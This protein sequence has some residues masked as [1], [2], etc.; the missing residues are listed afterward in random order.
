MIIAC[1]SCGTAIQ[2][3][4]DLESI[5]AL[6]GAKTEF[7]SAGYPCFRCGEKAQAMLTQQVDPEALRSLDVYTLSPEEALAA[8]CGLGIPEERGCYE[9]VVRSLFEAVGVKIGGRQL[10][11][12]S[13]FFLDWL[14]LPSG[15]RIYL[16]AGPSGALVYRITKPHSYVKKVL[17][18]STTP[19]LS[20]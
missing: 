19:L 17:D 18:E 6:V 8:L 13:R 7:A 11:S 2:I 9:E 16:G 12:S 15:H 14:E 5:D 1:I 10:R 20:T 3:I 4:G